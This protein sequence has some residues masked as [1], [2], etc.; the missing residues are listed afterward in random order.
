LSFI[1]AI[2]GFSITTSGHC[3]TGCVSTKGRFWSGWVSYVMMVA[4]VLSYPSK[5]TSPSPETC[6]TVSSPYSWALW[7]QRTQLCITVQAT[8]TLWGLHCDRT[9]KPPCRC[10]RPAGAF[11]THWAQGQP[12]VWVRGCMNFPL[13]AGTPTLPASPRGHSA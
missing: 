4:L 6:P 7:P 1:C 12:Q 9:R 3:S 10:S 8:H 5:S 2:S 13:E 11:R